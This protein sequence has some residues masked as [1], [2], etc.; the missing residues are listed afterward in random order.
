MDHPNFVL[1]FNSLVNRY[2][3]RYSK[4]KFDCVGSGAMDQ[5]EKKLAEEILGESGISFGKLLFLGI[6]DEESIVPF[7]QVDEGR[8]RATEAKV[9]EVRQFAEQEIDGS[10]IDR[11]AEIPEKVIAG[12]GQLGLMG[13]TIPKEYGGLGGSQYEYCKVMEELAVHCAATAILVNA[14][15]SIGLK[16]IL[17]FGTDEQKKKW[18]PGLARGEKIA[19][20]SL[21][22][23]NAGS[24]AAGIETTAVLDGNEWVINGK[25]QWTT[26]GSIADVLTVMAKVDGKV[27]A[28]IVEKG[29]K[30]LTITAPA[31][32]KVG[33]RG[34]RTTNLA[35]NNLRIPKG[36]VLGPIGG[37]LKVCLT[38]LDYGRT[39]F[40]ATC[41]G[42]AKDLL[43]RAKGH[44][45]KRVQ[46]KKQLAHFPMIQEKIAK[47]AALTY[48]MDAATYFTAGLVDSGQK[49]FMLEAAMLKVFASESLWDIIYQTMQIYGGRSF[50]TDEPLE[51]MMRDARL[52]MIGEGANEVLRVFIGVVGFREVG[53]R[54][55]SL[56]GGGKF[57]IW[58]SI[59][60]LL[61]WSGSNFDLHSKELHDEKIAIEKRIKVF[62]RIVF[63]LA[64]KHREEIIEEQLILNRVSTGVMALF[65][66]MA[67]LSKADVE[68]DKTIA[69]LYTKMALKDFDQSIREIS[70]NFD[71]EI[72]N[73]SIHITGVK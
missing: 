16:A 6:V 58:N 73:T 53:L 26:N 12:L 3:E 11:R 23:P 30:G 71:K 18:L 8:K 55:L 14:H 36:N 35:F 15:Q 5:E 1:H 72:T 19:A 39:T 40:G 52:N 64:I 24:D 43:E 37:G 22:E 29:T 32:E 47:I 49:D 13:L 28:F 66:S 61:A 51:R 21:T 48:A 70:G 2:I 4:N 65:T 57:S 46:F 34:T 33:I 41:T 9:E 68:E 17:L 27:T 63:Y 59:K 62:K 10:E 56:T 67:A 60:D 42:I 69:K 50:F 31:L 54:F 38:A 44:A 7:P 25:K 20:F 45:I